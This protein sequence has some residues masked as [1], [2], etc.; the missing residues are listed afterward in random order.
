[1]AR[2]KD[3]P[4]MLV[5]PK[6]HCQRC[7][8]AWLKDLEVPQHC[9]LPENP[10]RGAPI[11]LD[12]RAHVFL[13]DQNVSY[14]EIRGSQSTLNSKLRKATLTSSMLRSKLLSSRSSQNNNN[15]NNPSDS[16]AAMSPRKSKRQSHRPNSEASAINIVEDEKGP[17]AG[18]SEEEISGITDVLIS[19]TGEAEGDGIRKYGGMTNSQARVFVNKSLLDAEA[20]SEQKQQRQG[21]SSQAAERVGS[22][23]SLT[24]TKKRASKEGLNSKNSKKS[25]RGRRGGGNKKGSHPDLQ[26]NS[27]SNSRTNIVSVNSSQPNGKDG[28]WQG[29][30]AHGNQQQN[31]NGKIPVGLSTPKKLQ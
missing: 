7:Y 27:S 10:I 21:A 1:M 13:K 25:R 20:T 4:G 19:K 29:K 11:A 24:T 6:F 14:I 3:I 23:A 28:N 16:K 30:V 26:G 2:N 15:L 17:G 22:Q 12:D 18:K 5:I 9:D 31:A 8:E